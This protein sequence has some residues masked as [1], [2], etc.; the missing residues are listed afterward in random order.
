MKV[1]KDKQKGSRYGFILS[2]LNIKYILGEDHLLQAYEEF[3]S[4]VASFIQ[5][6]AYNAEMYDYLVA[7]MPKYILSFQEMLKGELE[8][9]VS[10][11]YKID[12]DF[13]QIKYEAKGMQAVLD[14]QELIRDQL[15]ETVP[16]QSQ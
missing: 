6:F 9:S 8:D 13:K 1:K 14:Y 7:I 3:R 4:G 12:D 5:R 11:I 10:I 2:L 15:Q 16:G